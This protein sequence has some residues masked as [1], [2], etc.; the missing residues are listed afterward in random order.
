MKKIL[1]ILTG[2]L[3]VFGMVG[4]S[5]RRSNIQLAAQELVSHI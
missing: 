3:L 1:L 5:S 4:G 2:F